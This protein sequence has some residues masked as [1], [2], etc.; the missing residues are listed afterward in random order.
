L[1]EVCGRW[2]FEY[3]QDKSQGLKGSEKRDM[4]RIN[5]RA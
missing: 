3:A 4:L 1:E 2:P 5:L